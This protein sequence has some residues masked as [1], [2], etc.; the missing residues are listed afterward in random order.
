LDVLIIDDEII[1]Q[2]ILTTFFGHYSEKNNIEI[3]IRCISDPA[4]A[5][6]ELATRGEQFDIITLDV[7]MP[8]LEGDKIFQSMKDNHPHL[9]DKILFVT[10][11]NADL[12]QQF[13]DMKLQVLAKPF[14]YPQFKKAV[15]AI[16]DQCTDEFR[17]H[18]T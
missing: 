11:Y 18:G 4:Q 12:L 6:F 1:I 7:R 10:G 16:L 2:D 8:K 9:V 17:Q 5:L 14:Q 13:P 15:E 3:N